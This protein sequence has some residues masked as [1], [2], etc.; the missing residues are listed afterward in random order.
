MR[1]D[2]TFEVAAPIDRVWPV[3]RDIPRVAGCIPG[4]QITE[5]VNERTYRAR[6]SVKVGPVAVSYK[7]TIVVESIDDATHTATMRVAGDELKGRG[8][9][10]AVMTT[11]AHGHA[12]GTRITTSTDAQISGIVASL[13]GRLIEGVAKKTLGQ[14]A[15]N[16]AALV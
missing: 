11:A 15:D 2:E 4:A 8:G 5:V 9:V 7:A 6:M 13:G 16:L 3:L 12:G 10:R 14:F 1:I